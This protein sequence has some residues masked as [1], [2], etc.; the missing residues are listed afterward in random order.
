[1]NAPRA[2]AGM[3]VIVIGGGIGGLTLALALHQV[4]ISS[5]V[6]EAGAKINPLGVGINLLPHAMQILSELGVAERLAATG[7]ET[8]EICFFTRHGQLV[9]REP[10]GRRAG[11]EWPQIS[12]H[13]AD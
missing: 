8:S 3:G 11:Y 5:R 9:D 4:G 12:I 2:L 6:F 7:I 10:R 13:R 1:M